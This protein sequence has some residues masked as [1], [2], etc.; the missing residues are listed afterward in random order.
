[1]PCGRADG[2]INGGC[3]DIT[4]ETLQLFVAGLVLARALAQTEMV[5]ALR[6]RA[7]LLIPV[8]V[9]A[10]VAHFAIDPTRKL[11]SHCSAASPR[12]AAWLRAHTRADAILGVGDCAGELTWRDGRR[13]VQLEG[14]VDDKR[15]ID[16]IRSRRVPQYMT[17][18]G[19]DYYLREDDQYTR[20][21]RRPVA[22]R[23]GCW[24][25]DEPKE[26][27]TTPR[28]YVVVCDR[29]HLYRSTQKDT[30]TWDIWRNRPELQQAGT[31]ARR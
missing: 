22:G 20:D 9:V 3:T 1:V 11:D 30:S 13:T 4:K 14:L 15:F 23:P 2:L 24:Q 8:A 19:V 31:A 18:A 7:W 28:S 5:S 12:V 10:A 25:F 27:R 16:A 21:R 6:P 26:G 29:D 17:A